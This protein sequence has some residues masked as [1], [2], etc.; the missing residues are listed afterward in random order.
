M[1]K[2]VILYRVYFMKDGDMNIV[3]SGGKTEFEE[4]RA[5]EIKRI[6]ERRRGK[7]MFL[8]KVN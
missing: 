2:Q 5:K 4:K 6:M 1:K 8:E 3:M 7:V